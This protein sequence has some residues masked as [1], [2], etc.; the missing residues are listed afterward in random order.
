LKQRIVLSGVNLNEMGPLT[1]FQDAIASLVAEYGDC[2]DIVALVHKKALFDI[3]GVTYIEYSEIKSSWLKRLRFEYHA[4]RGISRELK[5][6]LWFS[7]HDMTPNV[8]AEVKAVYCHNPAPFYAFSP[9]EA[10]HDWK[11]GLFTLL[12]RFLYEINIRSNNFV[13]VQQDWLRREFKSRYGIRNIVVAH[14]SVDHLVIPEVTS[15]TSSGTLY[16][17]FYPAYPRTFKNMEQLLKAAQRLER[18]GF[19]RFEL[20]LTVN[21]TETSYAA[22]LVRDFAS[23]TTVR[24]L[25]LLPRSKVMQLYAQADCLLFPSKLETWGMPITE[26]KATGKP[27]LAADLPYAHETVGTYAQ[28]AFFPIGN[29]AQLSDMMKQAVNGSVLCGPVKGLQIAQPFSQNWP[30]LWEILLRSS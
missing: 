26:F 6:Y 16:R 4:C 10:L 21:G 15:P 30:E 12:Y 13:V 19:N 25:G 29:D 27:I 3:P 2:Y 18:D 28:A 24:W 17:F 5:P 23:L 11:F 20:W 14:P 1:V 22:Q 9:R 8:E 7:M